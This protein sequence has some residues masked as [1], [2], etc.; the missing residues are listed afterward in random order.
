MLYD[1]VM[2]RISPEDGERRSSGGIVI[3]ATAQMAKRLAWGDV[4]GVGTS[5][6]HVKVGD[7]VMFNPED[8]LEVEV[9]GTTYLVMRERDLHAVATE[10]TE[11]G[12]GLYL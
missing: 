8:Q 11:H 9:H 7:R 2:V 6:R 12:T 3:P 10:L 4:F 5:V 1:R